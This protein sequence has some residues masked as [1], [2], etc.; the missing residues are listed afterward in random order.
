MKIITLVENTSKI[1][2]LKAKHGL[3]FYIETKMHKILFD[4]GPDN[5][6][7][8]NAEKLNVDISEVDTVIISHGH[9]DH[10][11]GLKTFLENNVKAKIY[12]NKN[13]FAPHYVK[14]TDSNKYIGL[15]KEFEKNERMVFVGDSL[16]IDEE[17]FLFSD[18]EGQ[19]KTKSNSVLLKE[20]G[21]EDDFIH[22]QNL[23]I[24][25]QGRNILFTG[26]SHRGITNIVKAALK[27]V[28]KIDVVIG[29]FHLFSA[30]NK[31]TE[32]SEVVDKL[33]AE[34]N[35]LDSKFYTCHCTGDQAFKEMKKVM[36]DKLDY[37]ATGDVLEI[38]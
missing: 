35:E 24:R 25:E 38:K 23:I 26:C 33:A 16:E 34:L 15:K 30:S 21:R 19:F 1:E 3:S 17:L 22:E 9:Y 27:H 36:E 8:L 18:V 4:L 28:E 14:S 5:T 11:G 37:I 20:D 32:P 2:N 6:F 13:A 12:I 10:G 31:V 29:G 7:F